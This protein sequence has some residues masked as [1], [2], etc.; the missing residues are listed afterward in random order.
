[1]FF[2]VVV[3]FYFRNCEHGRSVGSEKASMV[4]LRTACHPS[5]RLPILK[6]RDSFYAKSV[7]LTLQSTLCILSCG[8]SDG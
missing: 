7:K 5:F 1:M 4:D 6:R 8:N 3:K 2:K